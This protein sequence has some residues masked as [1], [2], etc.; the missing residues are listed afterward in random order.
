V[1]KLGGKERDGARV[2]KRYD[3]PQTPYR[4]AQAAGVLVPAAQEALAAHLAATGPV[5]LRRQLDAALA[6]VWARRVGAAAPPA[7]AR[8]RRLNYEATIPPSDRCSFEATR[9]Y[10]WSAWSCAGPSGRVGRAAT[11]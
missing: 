8:S 2:R 9:A 1:M 11:G 3:G 5:P 4:R 10:A 7:R 6:Q